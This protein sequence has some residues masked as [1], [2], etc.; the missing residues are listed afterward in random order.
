MPR[1]VDLA[2]AARRIARIALVDDDPMF[3]RMFA[4]NLQAAGYQTVCFDD[5]NQAL[6]S[7][8]RD[9][10]LD[11][12]VLDW[13]MPGLDGLALFK[14]LRAR[15]VAAP[16]LFLT[17]YGQPIFE[18]AALDAGAADF[19]DKSRGLAIILHRLSLAL[20]RRDTPAALPSGPGPADLRIGELLLSDSTKRATWRGHKV[21]LSL[22][23]FDVVALLAA[24]AGRDVGYRQIYDVVRGNGFVAGHGE[25]GYRANVRAMV[26]RIRRKFVQLDP[27]FAALQNYPGFGY[28]W[29][30]HG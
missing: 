7:L 29:H 11:A 12:Y 13:N 20:T 3:L 9:A 16:V 26:K 4:A 17:S 6:A 1:A 15:G 30:R 5:P 28:R 18:E 27:D 19:V 8:Q 24:S 23:E 25:D 2:D 10:P 21:P 22:N 14:S